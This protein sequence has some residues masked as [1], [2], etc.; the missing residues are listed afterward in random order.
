M[1]SVK[2]IMEKYTNA[3]GGKRLSMF[4][5]YRDLREEF[6]TIDMAEMPGR[7]G[8]PAKEKSKREL[9]RFAGCRWGWQRLCRSVR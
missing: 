6:T 9:G 7:E 1:E 3:D 2:T 4:L 8:F 5:T